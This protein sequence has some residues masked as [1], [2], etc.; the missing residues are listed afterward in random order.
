MMGQIPIEVGTYND[1]SKEEAEYQEDFELIRETVLQ[2]R[3]AEIARDKLDRMNNYGSSKM[4]RWQFESFIKQWFPQ[5]NKLYPT[6]REEKY[7]YCWNNRC[8]FESY[9]PLT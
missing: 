5:F 1:E 9:G 7:Y 2:L 8:D 4:C 6:F 3:G